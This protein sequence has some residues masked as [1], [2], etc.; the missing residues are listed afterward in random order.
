MERISKGR[1]YVYE[2]D[3]FI[4]QKH[5]ETKTLGQEMVCQMK[6]TG[7]CSAN[8]YLKNE[9]FVIKR[10]HNHGPTNVQVLSLRGKLKEASVHRPKE[11]LRS[12]FD[13]VCSGDPASRQIGFQLEEKR[14]RTAR[15]V[16]T[17][18]I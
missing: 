16:P 12:V 9:A 2:K 3:G 6:K 14:M 7:G 1:G 10:A 5:R 8:G 13:S 15:L 17:I 4:Y 11:P 18:I